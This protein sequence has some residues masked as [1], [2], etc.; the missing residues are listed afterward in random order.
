[1]EFNCARRGRPGYPSEPLPSGHGDVRGLPGNRT[2]AGRMT[3]RTG[4]EVLPGRPHGCPEGHAQALG[5]R[6]FLLPAAVVANILRE[7][8][9]LPVTES[10]GN[11]T[12]ILG[13][14]GSGSQT[15]P[16]SRFPT[17]LW[18]L[19]LG[20]RGRLADEAVFGIRTGG[21]RMSGSSCSRRCREGAVS[22]GGDGCLAKKLAKQGVGW[23]RQLRRRRPLRFGARLSVGV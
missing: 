15:L 8:H 18:G 4:M 17:R 19:R 2:S 5:F 12:M 7:N 10:P 9:F 22:K 21:E 16:R 1:M 13:S 20:G 11:R 6:D 3:S 14:T 23:P